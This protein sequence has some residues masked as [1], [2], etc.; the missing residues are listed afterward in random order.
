MSADL[1]LRPVAGD[2][3]FG[4]VPTRAVSTPASSATSTAAAGRTI[5]TVRITGTT[6]RP[7]GIRVP[8]VL[9]KAITPVA[10]VALWQVAASAGWLSSNTLASPEAVAVKAG[11][12]IGSGE[13]GRA[14]A[15]SGQRVGAGL[16]IGLSAALVAALI[17]G[18]FRRGE[19]V[20]DAPIQ[21]LRTVPVVGLIPLLIIWFGIGEEPKVILI[22]L[23]VFFPFYLNTF[24]GI[25]STDPHLIEA[26]R[27]LG[28]G[29][30]AQIR[31]VVLPSALPN[32]LVGLRYSIGVSW[33]LLVFAETINATSGI[34]YLIN[35]AREFFETDT[36]V[37]CLVL[38]ALLGLL[39]DVIVRTLERLL[40]QW[41]PTFTGT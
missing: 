24:A 37:L 1:T 25:R 35:T 22:A 32:A 34:G 2:H 36:I 13:L 14:I 6:R 23:G 26:G 29:R 9:I 10:L 11:E 39:A 8:R 5:R 41:R 12:L 15:A 31:H 7:S 40:L 3:S 38:Y 18:L 28:L 19:D 4:A 20:L 16:A 30:W 27:T 17:S 33:L 21:M